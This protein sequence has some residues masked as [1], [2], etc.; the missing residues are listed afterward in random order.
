MASFSLQ[1]LPIK[2]PAQISPFEA[3]PGNNP[4]A[5]LRAVDLLLNASGLS[6]WPILA[7]AAKVRP[8]RS[9]TRR[10]PDA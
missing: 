1:T 2:A 4:A 3:L 6:A 8:L 7:A 9:L 10:S 5:M